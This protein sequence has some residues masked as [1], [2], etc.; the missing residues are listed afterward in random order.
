MRKIKDYT[1]LKK[2][3]Y[4]YAKGKPRNRFHYIFY[5]NLDYSGLLNIE[6]QILKTNTKKFEPELDETSKGETKIGKEILNG[7]D[8]YRLNKSEVLKYTKQLILMKLG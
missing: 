3:Y 7:Y 4:L 1:K 5:V 8:I 2:G 6:Y